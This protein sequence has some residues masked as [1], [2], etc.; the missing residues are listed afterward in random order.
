M[1]IIVCHF[2]KSL[3]LSYCIWY[4]A[5]ITF[6]LSHCICHIAFVALHLPYWICYIALVALDLS[7]RICHMAFVQSHFSYLENCICHIP[8][9][10][11]SRK[12][13]NVQN[14]VLRK[15]GSIEIFKKILVGGLVG[16]P[17]VSL[18]WTMHTIMKLKYCSGTYKT[19]FYTK[20]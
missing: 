9:G 14:H 8:L 10:K 13:L 20:N 2:G 4:I 12:S 1:K 18:F 17:I 6:H 7:H 11:P 15:F 3:Y 16:D 5:F 19:N